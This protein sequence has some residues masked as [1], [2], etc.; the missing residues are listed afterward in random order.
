MSL[1]KEKATQAEG[2]QGG[3]GVDHQTLS[4]EGTPRTAAERHGPHSG[5]FQPI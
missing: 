4:H 2:G 5:P 1:F 3:K